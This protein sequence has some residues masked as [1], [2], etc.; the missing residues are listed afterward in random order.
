MRKKETNFLDIEKK[1]EISCHDHRLGK[2]HQQKEII[3][4]ISTNQDPYLY[5]HQVIKSRRLMP[6]PRRIDR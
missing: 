1:E 2:K 5:I 4:M 3:R 6:Y